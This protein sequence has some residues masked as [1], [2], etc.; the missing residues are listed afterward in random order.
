M[1]VCVCLPV[2]VYI[3]T[4]AATWCESVCAK[5]AKKTCTIRSCYTES[6]FSAGYVVFV[7]HIEMVNVLINAWQ[8]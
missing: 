7:H 3:H 2:C 6:I 5:C 4:A 8:L 1:P